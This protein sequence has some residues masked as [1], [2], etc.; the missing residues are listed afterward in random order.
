MHAGRAGLTRA[1]VA[2][3][4]VNDRMRG[5][6]DEQTWE[7]V[8]KLYV[9]VS[10]IKEQLASLTQATMRIHNTVGAK[11]PTHVHELSALADSIAGV[12]IHEGGP[13][14]EELLYNLPSTLHVESATLSSSREAI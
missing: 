8:R 3:G 2:G 5:V 6:N 9:S 4:V 11:D 10:Q 1:P 7:D 14:D 12:P 13:T